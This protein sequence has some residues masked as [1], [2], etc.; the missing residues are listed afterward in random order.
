MGANGAGK[1]TLFKIIRGIDAPDAGSVT[2]GET[3]KLMYVDQ[4]RDSLQADKTVYETM[5][6][7]AEEIDLGGR[8]VNARA[9]CS[10]YNFK[11][12]D[13]QKVRVLLSKPLWFM[14]S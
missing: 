13:Q 3:V 6:G 9:Y 7:G 10:W 11:G 4:D 12:S 1:T 2:V 5:S 14:I 8:K